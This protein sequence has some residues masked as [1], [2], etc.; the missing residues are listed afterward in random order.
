LNTTEVNINVAD[1]YVPDQDQPPQPPPP[2]AV[3]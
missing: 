3:R 1:L 2:P